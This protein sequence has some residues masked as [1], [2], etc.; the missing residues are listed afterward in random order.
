MKK[1]F[2]AFLLMTAMV[3]SVGTFV[4][5]NDFVDEMEDVK[6][7]A[8]QNAADIAAIKTQI[9]ALEQGIAEAKQDA[10]DA[11]TFAEKC[12]AEAKAEALTEAKAYAESLNNATM[13][14]LST[15]KGKVDGI[16]ATLTTL[17]GDFDAHVVAFNEAKTAIETQLAALEKYNKETQDPKIDKL[18]KDLADLQTEVTNHK[19]DF[20]AYKKKVDAALEDLR[21]DIEAVDAALTVLQNKILRSLVF[22]PQLY[23]DGIESLEYNYFKAETYDP[24]KDWIRPVAVKNEIVGGVPTVYATAFAPAFP[25]LD[26]MY[27]APVQMVDYYMNPSSADVTDASM[28]FLSKDA[29]VLVTKA[30]NNV[31]TETPSSAAK[32]NIDTYTTNGGILSVGI[33]PDDVEAMEDLWYD[34]L[35]HNSYTDDYATVVA[36]QVDVPKRGDNTMA[37][38]TSDWARLYPTAIIP[39]ALAYHKT[40]KHPGEPILLDKPNPGYDEATCDCKNNYDDLLNVGGHHL[41][42]TIQAAL[43]NDAAF[44]VQYNGSIDLTK[45][46]ELHLEYAKPLIDSTYFIW[47]V[48]DDAAQ[49]EKYGLKVNFQLIEQKVGGNET[50][51]S[52]YAWEPDAK[53]GIIRPC[54]VK[55]D[56]VT[57]IDPAQELPESAI[58]RC[59]IVLVTITNNA[60]EVV[61]YGFIKV[62]IVKD[63][64]AVVTDPFEWNYTF[65]DEAEH[66][67]TWAQV[68]ELVLEK[69]S[70]SK[71]QF[72][73]FYQ[74]V[75][76]RDAQGNVTGDLVQYIRPANA[77]AAAYRQNWKAAPVESWLGWVTERHDWSGTTTSVLEW[78]FT[79]CDYEYIYSHMNG[80]ATIYVG[81]QEIPGGD[82]TIVD[83]E[84][85]IFLPLTINVTKDNVDRTYGVK[86]LDYWFGGADD[87]QNARLNVERPIDNGTTLNWYSNLMEVWV[88]NKLTWKKGDATETVT[89]PQPYNYYFAPEQPSFEDEA[90]NKYVLSVDSDKVY[91]FCDENSAHAVKNAEIIEF[92]KSKMIDTEMGI[93]L[94]DTLYCSVNGAPREKIAV[95][96]NYRDQATGD[97]LY[98]VEYLHPE[99]WHYGHKPNDNTPAFQALNATPSIPRTAAKLYANIGI[100]RSTCGHVALPVADGIHPYYFLRPINVVSGEGKFL[101]A[102]AN[103]SYID[104]L[105]LLSFSDWRGEQFV[106]ESFKNVW[107]FAFY[108]VKAIRVNADEIMTNMKFEGQTKEWNYLTKI[109]NEI[110]ISYVDETKVEY[111][112]VWDDA[113]MTT[114]SYVNEF[115]LHDL[116]GVDYNY[117]SMGTAETYAEFVDVFGALKYHNNG[118]NIKS[119]DLQI[120]VYVTYEWG[121]LRT[122]AN[123]HVDQ[124][125]GND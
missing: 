8:T 103:G 83:N 73:K 31:G 35:N 48:V 76:S 52:K 77:Q 20:D 47:D 10:A 3:L 4:S 100:S 118:N 107:Y 16:D 91:H 66:V 102:E 45:V 33:R 114:K 101:D 59:P 88:G 80:T 63:V 56:K 6:A 89:V 12:A 120:P 90:G 86:I 39:A 37:T 41:H 27:I 36:L 113:E 64:L 32:F 9:T 72:D 42:K 7:Q 96:H 15:L 1:F 110:R 38:V 115:D 124:T 51:D 21:A 23:V 78:T 119:F 49:L 71:D 26:S 34:A 99:N 19:A 117:A 109:T 50:N 28:K 75:Y 108:D 18:I 22:D 74:P 62:E 69:M 105:E 84:P 121:T 104:I 67:I 98:Y 106:T 111:P 112:M 30:E 55:Q 14:E 93:Y 70:L 11:K 85:S 53:N 24:D 82:V 43:E 54:A 92:E 40:V 60:G 123:V 122:V 125:M 57:Q 17:K 61:L 46:L 95:L 68:S 81:Y 25:A 58:G 79:E 116:D 65:C 2:S 94:N 29:R 5:C 97:Y 87:K 13:E 44:E